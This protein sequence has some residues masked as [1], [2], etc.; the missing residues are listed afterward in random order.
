M[1]WLR[2]YQY[3]NDCML[4]AEHSGKNPWFAAADGH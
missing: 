1:L 3:M 2:E 4:T